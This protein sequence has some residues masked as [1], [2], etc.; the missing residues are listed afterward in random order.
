[1]PG[2]LRDPAT[3]LDCTETPFRPPKTLAISDVAT[4]ASCSLIFAAPIAG[5][6]GLS[7][8]PTKDGLSVDESPLAQLT[9]NNSTFSLYE[10]I[11]WVNGAHR[12]F[13]ATANF[14]LEMNMYFHDIYDSAKQIAVAIPITIDDSQAKPYF[15]EMAA[16]QM[17]R[18][19]T[20]E[21]IIVKNAPVLTYK[22]IDL[23]SRNKSSPKSAPQCSSLTSNLTW[24]VLPTTF[25]S[26]GDANRLRGLG[27]KDDISPPAADH[28]LSLERARSL[29]MVVAN[30]QLKS[31]ITTAKT[32]AVAASSPGIYLTRAL[33]CQR[34][35]PTKDVRNNAVYL[36]NA[37]Q[38]NTLADELAAAAA[39]DTP[40]DDISSGSVRPRDIET[41]L[42]ICVGIAVGIIIFAIVAYVVLQNVY[43]GYLPA[44]NKELLEVPAI[45]TAKEA[46][47]AAFVDAQKG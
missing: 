4:C 11:L 7:T 41:I 27:G 23:R 10:T 18:V 6:K 20:L 47:C 45:T 26:T 30:I 25:I 3:G 29:T 17:G 13:K 36:K 43:K 2:V 33:Q 28:E 24:F 5:P 1:M 8:R 15:T 19:Y 44:V 34:I 9:F 14:D 35:D 12:N 40:L 38:N 32:A 46:A 37:P 22:G 39:L 31:D 16:Q 21:S 42:S